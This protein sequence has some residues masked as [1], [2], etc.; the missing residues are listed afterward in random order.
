V[1]RGYAAAAAGADLKLALSY[2]G[3]NPALILHGP[4]PSGDFQGVRGAMLFSCR[5]LEGSRIYL[6]NENTAN[7]VVK[8]TGWEE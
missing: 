1:L 8:I 4:P 3:T 7:Q 2:D 6:N 5:L